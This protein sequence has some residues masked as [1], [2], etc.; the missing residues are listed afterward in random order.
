MIR[1]L[2]NKLIVLAL[3]RNLLILVHIKVQ[4]VQTEVLFPIHI[5]ALLI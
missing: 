2:K 4:D 5:V 3:I 1:L